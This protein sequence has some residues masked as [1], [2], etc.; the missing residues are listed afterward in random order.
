M[1]STDSETTFQRYRPLLFAI[2]YRMTGSGMEADDLLQDAYLR[3]QAV[4]PATVESAKAMLTTIVTRLAI[5]HLRSAR[6]RRETYVGPWLP[7]PVAGA[8]S[9]HE[10]APDAAHSL[11]LTESLSTAFLLLLERLNPVERA[12][13]LLHDV[14]DYDYED[15]ADIIDKSPANCRQIVR[16]ARE[17]LRNRPRFSADTDAQADLLQHFL[18]AAQQGEMTPLLEHLAADVTMWSDGG[19]KSPASP[20]PIHGVE[21]VLQ[22]LLNL[23]K[24][25]ANVEARTTQI[26]GQTGWLILVAG[27]L[28][29]VMTFSYSREEPE[30]V[31]AIYLVAN[32]DKLARLAATLNLPLAPIVFRGTRAT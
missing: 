19:G 24:Q 1:S 3:W 20:R 9:A 6:V 25:T 23:Y 31:D 12:A 7:E 16:R 28:R 21:K 26:N 2:A 10:L 11:L 17:H 15:V 18:Q 14:F 8:D 4:D 32:P 5:D 27:A 22:I 29:G 30:R 13:F